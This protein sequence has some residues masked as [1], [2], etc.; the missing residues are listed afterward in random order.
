MPDSSLLHIFKAGTHTDQHGRK[1]TIMP[2]EIAASAAAYDPAVHEA[3]IVIGHP[4]TDDPAYGW[5][6]SLQATDADLEA[7]PHE[8]DPVFAEWV[9]KKY[10]KKISSSFYLPDSPGNPK[11]GVYYL[12]HVGFLGAQPPAIKGLRQAEFSEKE[13]GTVEFADWGMMTSAS[14]FSRLREF[15]ISKFGMEDADSV[16][17]SWQ[18]DTLRDEAMREDKTVQTDP[19]FQEPIPVNPTFPH[20]DTMTKE[21]I[22]ALQAENAR[23]KADAATRLAADVKQRQETVHTGNVAFAEK[24]VT[25]GRLVPA[26]KAVVIALLDE[27]SKGEQPVEF[28]EGEVKKPLAS[29]FKELLGGATPVLDFSEHATKDRVNV[30]LTTTSAEFAEADPERLAL[31]QKATALAKKEGISYDAAVARCL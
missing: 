9:K 19:A 14:L 16:L 20:E 12:R 4:K 7:V 25:E 18:L 24:L 21:E 10:Y 17:P 8:V 3:P 22:E 13:D 23:L 2:E 28:A 15:L 26:A 5:I 31:H 6:Q 30:D 29:A 1:I 27:V 11:P